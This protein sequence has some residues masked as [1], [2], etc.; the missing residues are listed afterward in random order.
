MGDA[1]GSGPPTVA[2]GVDPMIA[3]RPNSDICAEVVSDPAMLA[4]LV[5]DWWR[6]W[7][8]AEQPTAFQSPAWLLPWWSV[9]GTGD[10]YAIA[11]WSEEALVGFAPLYRRPGAPIQPLGVG[12][13]DQFDLLIDRSV[14]EAGPMLAR[15]I[16]A[17]AD[18]TATEIE[19]PELAAGS[20]AGRLLASR[21]R[22]AQG[23]PCP[24]LALPEGADVEAVVPARRRR[25][26]RMAR[27]R[28]E[29]AGGIAI[30]AVTGGDAM[31]AIGDLVRLQALRWADRDQAPVLADPAF[32]TFLEAAAV[33]LAGAGLLRLTRLRVD[34]GVVAVQLGLAG[35]GHHA[36]YLGAFDPAFER[37]SPGAL[38]MG[39]AIEAAI[40]E[41][42]RTFRFLRGGEAYKF[43]WGA[44][45][46]SN[47]R[48]VIAPRDRGH[49][50]S[51]G[52]D[53]FVPA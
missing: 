11:V 50:S 44:V 24:V 14:P 10:L 49:P 30:E 31:A 28:A 6:L 35:P 47:A 3:P 1:T 46:R 48:M 5:A 29:T 18:R 12:I 42:A 15:A 33:P 20:H 52:G 40:A 4:G 32:R 43:A 34:D 26:L 2:V 37:I 9:F 36:A 8:A 23:S 51:I 53:V 17:L 45:D 25:K 21:G 19:L 22:L 16:A 13:S 27:H 7:H 41:G 38:L 39:A